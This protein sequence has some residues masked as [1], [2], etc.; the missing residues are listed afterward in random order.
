MSRKSTPTDLHEARRALA[1]A[2]ATNFACRDDLASP[3]V[4]GRI[5]TMLNVAKLEAWQGN[6]EEV[7][8]V[9]RG[10]VHLAK[11][12]A[13]SHA[14]EHVDPQWS[15]FAD[16]A[17]GNVFI[18]GSRDPATFDTSQRRVKIFMANL[19]AIAGE[20]LVMTRPGGAPRTVKRAV[21][22]VA[23]SAADDETLFPL[24]TA[25]AIDPHRYWPELLRLA[26]MIMTKAKYRVGLT[27]EPGHR[28]RGL[29]CDAQRK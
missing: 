18:D 27:K 5:A 17:L 28:A 3:V 7:V 26:W 13:K 15:Q 16:Y 14:G 11:H 19:L 23:L 9:G 1:G 12:G 22:V 6:P 8:T 20:Y 25:T 24:L 21:R 10:A 29:R 4:A 2:F